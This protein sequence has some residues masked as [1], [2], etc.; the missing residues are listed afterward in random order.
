MKGACSI[1]AVISLNYH[2]RKLEAPDHLRHLV[3]DIARAGKYIVQKLW[4]GNVGYAGTSNEFGEE[5]VKMDVL[6]N[7]IMERLLC[8]NELVS[9]YASEERNEIVNLHP[10]APY[11][12]VF[13]PLDGSSL[14]DSNF[15]IGTI[16]GVY[17]SGD[18]VGRTPR[19]QVAAL[20][21]LY[22]PRTMLT[23][24]LGSGKG[25]HRFVL[26]D[27]GEFVLDREFLGVGDDA[28]VYAPGNISAAAESP[29]Y[30]HL[31]TQWIAEKKTLR[32]SG[33][34]VPDIH[35]MLAKGNGVFVNI[36]GAKY[37]EGKLRLVYECG[38]FAYI[39]EEAG[40][41]SSDG[42]QSLLDKTI[43]KIDQRTQIIIG[44]KNEVKRVEKTLKEMG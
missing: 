32:Y 42:L 23:Y 27:I 1:P 8:E 17:E 31:M 9:C 30:K 3:V 28:K 2:L 5:Q 44:S 35:H 7:D 12:V 34:M 10:S 22:G 16:V 11:S 24:T 19:Q 15:T 25:V 33:C 26:N 18:I 4:H 40:G 20:Y 29:A 21:I 37:P 36:G 14:V 6:S 13:D 38:P 39:V 43:E 41:A